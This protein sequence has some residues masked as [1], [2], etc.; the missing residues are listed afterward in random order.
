MRKRSNCFFCKIVNLCDI[1]HGFGCVWF[2]VY[3]VN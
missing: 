1:D 3:V 2:V